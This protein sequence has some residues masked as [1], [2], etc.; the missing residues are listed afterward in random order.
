MRRVL[1]ILGEYFEFLQ[2]LLI[3]VKDLFSLLINAL[4]IF[5]IMCLKL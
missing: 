5:L 2:C 4:I 3:H 1:F